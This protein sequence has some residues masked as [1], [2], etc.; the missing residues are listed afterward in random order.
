MD[1]ITAARDHEEERG[2][3]A[4]QIVLIEI[5]LHI[6][7]AEKPQS[8]DGIKAVAQRRKIARRVVGES[9]GN[10]AHWLQ[11]NQFV[12]AG[13]GKKRQDVGGIGSAEGIERDVGV[14]LIEVVFA[15]GVDA[16]EIARLHD[17]PAR[18]ADLGVASPTGALIV[19]QRISVAAHAGDEFRE[20]VPFA[21]G[22]LHAAQKLHG[23]LRVRDVRGSE[24]ERRSLCD[25]GR[26]QRQ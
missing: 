15:P 17:G 1:R 2:E 20:R 4:A 18:V 22:S 14:V 26:T 21:V 8:D 10:A 25:R 7:G 24:H 6:V 9:S 12:I 16:V 13:V 5:A 11:A 19:G 23:R 3:N